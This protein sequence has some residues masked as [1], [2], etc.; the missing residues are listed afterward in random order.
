[1]LTLIAAKTKMRG[2]QTS[3]Y[4]IAREAHP[5]LPIIVDVAVS[6]KCF[7]VAASYLIII[8]YCNDTSLV[9]VAA[10]PLTLTTLSLSIYIY[11]PLSS[12]SDLMPDAC[13]QMGCAEGA[14]TRQIWV[15]I[16]FLIAAP[17]CFQ[18]R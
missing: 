14:Q 6:I 1:M 5:Y 3:F 10:P 2:E 18:H 9:E 15:F 7:G 16:G 13:S 17:L 11:T 12:N 8:R 4:T